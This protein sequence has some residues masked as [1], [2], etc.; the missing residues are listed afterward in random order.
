MP[1]LHGIEDMSLKVVLCFNLWHVTPDINW[2]ILC[3]WNVM[4]ES[5][6]WSIWSYLITDTWISLQHNVHYWSKYGLSV[7]LGIR[8]LL[9]LWNLQW[10]SCWQIVPQSASTWLFS[11]PDKHLLSKNVK[12]WSKKMTRKVL[13]TYNWFNLKYQFAQK[14]KK[15][16][17]VEFTFSLFFLEDT[18][19]FDEGSSLSEIRLNVKFNMKDLKK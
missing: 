17:P 1:N 19:S 14:W 11:S 5:N 2:N 9:V 16:Y 6:K 4:L 18:L 8:W 13:Y 12:P 3:V 10:G 7:T 15:Y